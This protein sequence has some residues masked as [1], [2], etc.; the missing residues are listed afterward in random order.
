MALFCRRRDA[1]GGLF[2]S[3]DVRSHCGAAKPVDTKAVATKA[4]DAR[5]PVAQAD[6]ADSYQSVTPDANIS[7]RGDTSPSGA[8]SSTSDAQNSFHLSPA[9]VAS[10]QPRITVTYQDADIRD[11]IAAFATFS[12]RTIV[13]GKDVTGTITAEI[14]NQ[15]WDVALR[16]IL[17]GQGLAASEDAL[18]GIITVDSYKNIASKQASEPLVTQLVAVNYAHAGSLVGTLTGLLSRDCTPG[19]VPQAGNQNAQTS[20]YARGAVAADTAT[21]TLLITETP[22]RMADLWPM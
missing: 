6:V 20:C 4:A 12:G 2:G 11:V 17:Q 21:N 14:K 1:A 15:P 22:S 7:R 19:G 18:T 5:P 16:A 9:T 3:S 13:V 8:T 10:D